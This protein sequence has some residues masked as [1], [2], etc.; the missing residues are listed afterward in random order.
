MFLVRSESGGRF[1]GI[2]GVSAV[3]GEAAR[4]LGTPGRDVLVFEGTLHPDTGLDLDGVLKLCRSGPLLK[5]WRQIR[6][7]YAGVY[8]TAAERTAVAFTDHLGSHEV[9]Y[10]H[11]GARFAVGDAF[12]AL[13]RGLPGAARRLDTAAAEEFT[14]LGLMVG[15]KTFAGG[16]RRLAAGSTLTLRPDGAKVDRFWRYTMDSSRRPDRDLDDAVDECWALLTTSADRVRSELGANGTVLL[17]LS[18]GMDSRL[19]A[20]LCRQAGIRVFPYFFGERQSD[21]ARVAGAVAQRLGLALHFPGSNRSF[22]DLFRQSVDHQPMAD[23]EWCKYLTGREDLLR[24]LPPMAGLMSGH[25]GD[26]LLGNWSPRASRGP[27]DDGQLAAELVSMCALEPLGAQ[28]AERIAAAVRLQ[29]AEIGGSVL[30]RKQ[31]FWFHCMNPS[32]RRCGLF[33][34]FSTLPHFSLFEEAGVTDFALSLPPRWHLRN[35]FYSR[36]YERHAPDLHPARLPVENGSND[37][38]P[39]ERWLTGNPLLREKVAELVDLREPVDVCDPALTFAAAVAEITAG[40]ASRTWIHRFFR[41]LTVRAY[42]HAF[43]EGGS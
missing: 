4:V 24:A 20:V 28:A 5:G 19:T 25:L 29:L 11:D 39:V 43:E 9:Y 31:G 42:Q 34:Q 6:G 8:L 36:L 38:K 3:V 14:A 30:Q 1:R 35:R 40:R 33:H 27:D 15:G 2:P 21:A 13:V 37:H 32:V 41:H 23:L 26:H 12:A 10:W 22:P 17:G 16:V 18:G 7:R